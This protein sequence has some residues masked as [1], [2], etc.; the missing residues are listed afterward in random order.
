MLITKIERQKNNEKR[1][2]VYIDGE[3]AFGM[4]GEDILYFKL[5]ENKELDEE[6]Y[7]YITEYVLYVKAREEA[8]NYLGF[9]ARTE[10]ELRQK[11]GKSG[12]LEDISEKVIQLMKKYGYLN[13]EAYVKNYINDRKKFKPS[14]KRLI[15]YELSQKGISDEVISRVIEE[16]KLDETELA[17]RVLAKKS[18]GKDISDRKQ[19]EKLYMYL[20]GKGFDYDTINSA[21]RQLLEN[22]EGFEDI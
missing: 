13:D 9:K 16:T 2:S 4:D 15:K 1:Y 11:L 20:A 6:K 19:K 21:F 14:G 12:Y 5:A 17:A 8:Y 7:K 3:F 18:R 22:T 10:K